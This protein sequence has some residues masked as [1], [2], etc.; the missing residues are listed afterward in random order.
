ME[1]DYLLFAPGEEIDLEKIDTD[2]C[3][4]F[5]SEEFAQESLKRNTGRLMEYQDRFMAHEPVLV[6]LFQGMDASGK[7]EAITHVLSSLAPRGCEFKQFR[8]M[9]PKEEKHDYLWR[10]TSGLP[11]R[12]Q[13]GIFNRSY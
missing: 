8:T 13:I 4:G 11:A 7:D 5:A 10:V 6:L 3:M 2:S 12:G 1:Q 9:T